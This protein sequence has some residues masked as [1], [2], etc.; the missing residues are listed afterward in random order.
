LPALQRCIE[1]LFAQ[2]QDTPFE[3]ILVD[4]DT[5]EA[6][7]LAFLAGLPTVA[8]DRIQV[9]KVHGDFNF[10][11]LINLAARHGRGEFLL[12]LNNDTAALHPEWLHALL[13]EMKDP[14]VG[15]VAPRL[16]F[17]NGRI[18]HAG[19][20]LG[21]SGAADYPWV[22][23]PM[24]DPGYLGLLSYP[25]T[26]SAVSGAAMLIRR[27]VFDALGGMDEAYTI[28][29]GDIDFCLRA[30]K[31]GYRCIWTPR[32]TLLHEAGQTLR[33]VFATQQATESAQRLFQEARGRLL[34]RWLPN[35][36]HDPAYNIN[37]S[38]NSRSF[39]LETNPVLQPFGGIDKGRVRVLAMPADDGGSGFYRVHQPASAATQQ[40]LAAARLAPGYPAPIQFERLGIQTLFSQRQVDD[41]HLQALGEL[42]ELLPDLRIVIDFD[43]LLT[44][45]S[46][47]NIHHRTV[48]KDMSRRLETLGRLCNCL[49]VS[50]A[51]LAD[52]MHAYHPDIRCI[53][54]AIDSRLWPSSAEPNRP[55]TRKL[56]VG[57]AGGISH[58][59]DLAL[60][61]A[62]VAKLADEVDWVFFG[63]CLE[64]MRP[65]L[66]EFHNGVSVADYPR[67]L[68]ELD[69]DLAIAPLEINRFNE[70]KSNLR[71]L[72]Y[73]VLGIPVVATDI[74]PYRCGLPVTLVDNRP[75]SWIRAIRERINER[76]ALRRDGAALRE[77]VLRDWTLEK[78]LPAWISAWKG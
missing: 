33:S 29:Y 66:T 37:L 8:P 35:L 47:H 12:L 56:R 13:A 49:T 1:T 59:G 43:D 9:V 46:H 76:D 14:E 5:R 55:G 78:T 45:V 73:G 31:A 44:A 17:P 57:W 24:D 10:S 21:L 64:D 71:L 26:V 67:K 28:A 25:H 60:I 36:A 19:A 51:P 16:V 32:A 3:L 38:L 63:M 34:K 39:E 72:E 23:T 7:A 53:P 27:A 68:A 30:A 54:N 48:W 22:G 77:A 20:I 41:N 4:H 74:L 50:T 15:I 11:A 58:A 65:H 52:A 69:L 40:N 42:R 18:Q 70:C 6:D 75:Q 61:R 62:L 2:T